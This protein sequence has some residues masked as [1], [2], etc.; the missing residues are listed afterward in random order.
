M[1]GPSVVDAV[2]TL[3]TLQKNAE[4]SSNSLIFPRKR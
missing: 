4:H 1:Q 2:E 3:A